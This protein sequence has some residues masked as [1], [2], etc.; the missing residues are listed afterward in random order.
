SQ[1]INFDHKPRSPA[2]RPAKMPGDERIA[3][4][5]AEV[6]ATITE[7]QFLTEVER[8]FSCGSCMGCGQCSMYCTLACYT[9]LEEVGPGMYFSFMLDACK[10]CGKCIEVCPSGFLEAG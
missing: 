10:E 1:Q 4:G 5:E 6:A 9:R 8:C 2:V 7:M 3:K